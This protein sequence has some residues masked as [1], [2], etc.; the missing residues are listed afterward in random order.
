[1]KQVW[2]DWSRVV[3]LWVTC[4]R[5]RPSFRIR[6]E[7]EEEEVVLVRGEFMFQGNVYSRTLRQNLDIDDAA[8]VFMVERLFE[9]MQDTI[10]NQDAPRRKRCDTCRHWT[11]VHLVSLDEETNV[12]TIIARNRMGVVREDD[13]P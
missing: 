9:E 2:G 11:R 1:M 13:Q 6:V 8:R 10:A 12:R 4:K 5:W 7:V 3:E